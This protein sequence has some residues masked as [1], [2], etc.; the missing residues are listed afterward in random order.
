[1]EISEEAMRVALIGL[2]KLRAEID[3]HIQT[4]ESNLNPPLRRKYQK[5]TI[6]TID[7][8]IPPPFDI[9]KPGIPDMPIEYKW[10]R[11]GRSYHRVW[12]NDP[13]EKYMHHKGTGEIIMTLDGQPRPKTVPSP[14]NLKAMAK[15][16]EKAWVARRKL[17][18]SAPL[19]KTKTQARPNGHATA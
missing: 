18:K 7:T 2:Q 15:A 1:M 19:N 12:S 16:R 8:V 5:H 9:T 14:A 13:E 3:T 10:V 11:D 4:V 6:D 17:S